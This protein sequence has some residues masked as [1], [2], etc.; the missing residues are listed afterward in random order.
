[1]L[2]F[3]DETRYK[4][5][6]HLAVNPEVTQRDLAR[7]MGI[8]LGKLNFCLQ[9]LAEK[10][11]VKAGNFSRNPMKKRYIY[12]LTPQGMETKARLTLEFIQHKMTEYET[13]RREIAELQQE[14][15]NLQALSGHIPDLAESDG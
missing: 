8:S 2:S 15:Q 7:E 13:L 12:L 5:L 4:L 10:G 1:M 6:C 9:A 11:L 14:A 3:S